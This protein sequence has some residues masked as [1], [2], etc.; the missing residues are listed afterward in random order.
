MNN[1]HLLLKWV[2]GICAL[3]VFCFA[4]LVGLVTQIGGAANAA[5]TSDCTA[6]PEASTP[7]ALSTIAPA[8]ATATATSSEERSCYPDSQYGSA[9]VQW[10][11]QMAD[12]LYINP[13]CGST[14]GGNCDDTWYTSAFPQPVVAYGQTWC[15]AHGDCA[16]WANGSYQCVSFVRGAYSQVYPMTFTNDAF[17][18]WATYQHAPGW[19]EIPSLATA[20]P[21]QRFL[22]EPGDVMVFKDLS[23]GHVAIV[24]AVQPPSGQKNGWIAFANA[25]SSS[26]YDRMPLL[27][28]FTVDT[29]EWALS[30]ENYAVW[31]YIRPKPA[32]SQSVVRINQLEKTQYSSAAEWSTWAYSACSAAAMTEILNAY[33]FH[34]RIH[35]VLIVESARRDIDPTLGLTYDGGIADTLAQFGLKTNWGE[36]WS[37]AQV[38]G[39]A[40]SGSPVIVG[41]PPDRYAGGHV[42]VVTGGDMA[43]GTITIADSSSWDRQVVSVNQFLQW[44]AGFAAVALPPS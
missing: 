36:H 4:L 1:T 37:L 9:V 13:S 22:P 3:L 20:D 39:T 17:G 24:M 35:D 30:G 38:V 16:D 11:K 6:S 31:G 25:N 27:P 43:S 33:G 41:W 2:L 26:A 15:K 42:V 34:L 5:Q 32:L 7:V 40:N 28:N 12:A 18:L 8:H 19:Q 21:A 10:A 29:S 44:W 23:V 14:R